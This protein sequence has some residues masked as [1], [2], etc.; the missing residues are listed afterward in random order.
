LLQSSQLK[1]GVSI[2]ADLTKEE[3]MKRAIKEAIEKL[4]GLDILINR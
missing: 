3:D 2:V 4:G 1:H